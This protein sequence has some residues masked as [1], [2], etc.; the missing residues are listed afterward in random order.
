MKDIDQESSTKIDNQM[1]QQEKPALRCSLVVI[2]GPNCG[3]SVHLSDQTV[4]VGTSQECDLKVDDE[5][6]SRV[7]LT[8][9]QGAGGFQVVDRDSTNGSFYEGSR[10]SQAVVPAGAALK[11]GKSSLII[12]VDDN[13]DAIGLSPRTEFGQLVGRSISMRRLFAI[14]GQVAPTDSTVLIEGETGTGK[15]LVALALHEASQLTS[16][17]FNIFDCAAV[18]EELI[19]SEL[20]GHVKGSFTGAVSD[21]PGVF[22][23]T[24]NGTLL[25]DELSSLPMPLQPKLLR[26]LE[27]RKVKPVGSDEFR[28]INVRVV[29]ACNTDIEQDVREGRFRPDLFYRLSVV[30]VRIPP[31]RQRREDISPIVRKMITEFGGHDPGEISGPNLDRLMAHPWPGN[32]R[33]LRNVIERAIALTGGHVPPFDEM[34]LQIGVPVEDNELRIHTEATYSDAKAMVLDEFERRYLTE[35]MRRCKGNISFAS[36][37]SALDRKHLKKLLRRHRLLN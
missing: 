29:A 24:R 10:I 1:F 6:V 22:V 33:E 2:D 34:H 30:H 35:L 23:S 18:P 28:P 31:L 5:T 16:Q 14:L 15:E 32:V 36:R 3:K 21:R 25:L 26:V 27:S 4:K 8:V 12:R 9:C 20:F 17:P 11:I 7:H 13:P 37:V 19:E